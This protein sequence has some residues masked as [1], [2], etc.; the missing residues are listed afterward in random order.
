MGSCQTIEPRKYGDYAMNEGLWALSDYALTTRLDA[1][2]T[3]LEFDL[4]KANKLEMAFDLLNKRLADAKA[5]HD[6]N[7]AEWLREVQTTTGRA[8]KQ[9]TVNVRIMRTVVQAIEDE[10]LTRNLPRAAIGR[11]RYNP[12]QPSGFWARKDKAVRND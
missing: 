1:A 4:A 11:N 6:E 8:W 2:K 12:N 10:L 7:R 5:A 9:A 3:A